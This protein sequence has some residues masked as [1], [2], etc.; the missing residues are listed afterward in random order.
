MAI[1]WPGEPPK[2]FTD[3][4][5]L[6]EAIRTHTSGNGVYLDLRGVFASVHLR[7]DLSDQSDLFGPRLA[8]Q[9]D[10]ELALAL[11]KSLLVLGWLARWM[12]AAGQAT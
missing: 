12:N 4:R 11:L 5:G 6:L 10:I 3:P 9:F 8:T 7:F 2:D 1:T